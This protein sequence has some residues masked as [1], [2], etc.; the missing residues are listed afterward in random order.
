MKALQQKSH[1]IPTGKLQNWNLF[2]RI[3][4][5]LGIEHTYAGYTLQSGSPLSM[6][7]DVVLDFAEN[8]NFSTG[9]RTKWRFKVAAAVFETR[10]RIT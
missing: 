7:T 9:L 2:K 8:M 6:V 3:S 10:W 1:S 4:S 5:V